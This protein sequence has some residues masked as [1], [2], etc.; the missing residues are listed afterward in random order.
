MSCIEDMKAYDDYVLERYWPKS[1]SD[2]T[3]R[4]ALKTKLNIGIVKLVL[5]ASDDGLST[6]DIVSVVDD[7]GTY[8]NK[9]RDYAL[10]AKADALPA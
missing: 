9:V 6:N 2:T 3:R 10:K 7:Y 8:L 5:A 4:D 1:G